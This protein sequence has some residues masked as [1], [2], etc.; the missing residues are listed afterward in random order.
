LSA[1]DGVSL[2]DLRTKSL[3]LGDFFLAQLEERGIATAVDCITPREHARRGSQIS[4]LHPE[5]WGISQALIEAGVIVDFRA[6]DVVRFGFAP[7]YNRFVDAEAAA[8]TL[9][10]VL[11]E[12]RHRDPRFATRSRVT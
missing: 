3:A 8:A 5:A 10:R 9:G 2:A 1:F 12:A 11:A 7:L 4:L 6:P